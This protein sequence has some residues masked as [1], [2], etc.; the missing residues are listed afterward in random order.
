MHLRLLLAF[1]KGKRPAADAVYHLQTSVAAWNLTLS[2]RMMHWQHW[3]VRGWLN[4]VQHSSVAYVK[5]SKC[6]QTHTS[7]KKTSCEQNAMS[8]H[9]AV[10]VTYVKLNTEQEDNV[11]MIN[12]KKYGR[13]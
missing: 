8:F 10:S 1:G 9:D 12:W 13:N 3:M 4:R 6:L 5:Y 2:L 11:C 7:N